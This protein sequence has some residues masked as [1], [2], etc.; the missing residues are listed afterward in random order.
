MIDWLE[1]REAPDE[2]IVV[3][4]SPDDNFFW[5]KWESCRSCDKNCL[6]TKQHRLK[7]GVNVSVKK[8][9]SGTISVLACLCAGTPI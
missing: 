7:L 9:I 1:E 2:E 4:K 6:V 3:K 8:G 5:L